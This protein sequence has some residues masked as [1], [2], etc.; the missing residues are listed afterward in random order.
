MEDEVSW[1]F[2]KMIFSFLVLWLEFFVLEFEFCDVEI[3]VELEFDFEI[4]VNILGIDK[5]YLE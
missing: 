2:F 3:E 4:I 1:A 5:F